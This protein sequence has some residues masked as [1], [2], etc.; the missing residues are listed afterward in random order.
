M[1]DSCYWERLS[2]I[3]GEVSDTIANNYSAGQFFVSVEASDFA[4]STS[5]AL[6]LDLT[7]M[8][9]PTAIMEP[10]PTMEPTAMMEPTAAPTTAVAATEAPAPT[11]T[12]TE[13]TVEVGHQAGQKAPDFTLT[14]VEG[15]Q[16]SLSDFQ[17]RPVMIYFYATW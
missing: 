12:S 13:V 9:E 17:D 5:C 8:M 10:A 6:E 7:A 15:G 4:L 11:T 1:F 16:V 14:T 3:S 2:G